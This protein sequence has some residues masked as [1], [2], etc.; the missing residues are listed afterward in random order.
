MEPTE[1]SLV[2]FFVR[3]A[4][5]NDVL[6]KKI[7]QEQ[8]FSVDQE[9]WC[10]TLPELYRFLQDQ[11]IIAFSIGYKVYR[12]IIYNSFINQSIKPYGAEIT[13]SDNCNKVDK[14]IYALVWHDGH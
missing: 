12:K 13:I 7:Q 3:V 1:H 5:K 4:Q 8:C 2:S 10:F 14:S 6:L 9:R 11:K